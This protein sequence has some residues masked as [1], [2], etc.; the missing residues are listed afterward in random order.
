M[1]AHRGR[2][3]GCSLNKDA[4]PVPKIHLSPICACRLLQLHPHLRRQ[5]LPDILPRRRQLRSLLDQR[6]RPPRILVR[7]I[8]RHRIHIAPLL[9]RTSRRNPRARILPASTTSTPMLI[10]LSVRLRIG[11]FCGAGNVP[12]GNSLTIARPAPQS[13]PPASCSPSDK[14]HRSPSPKPQPSLLPPRALPYARTYPRP[15][16]SRS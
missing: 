6:I 2:C 1:L 14:S 12:S 9:Q 7:R 15:A 16:P 13:A 8:P 4:P 5:I 3:Q 10:P 11:K